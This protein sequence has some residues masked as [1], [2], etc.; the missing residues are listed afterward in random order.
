MG[1]A[2][3]CF[4]DE[5]FLESVDAWVAEIAANSAFS[6]AANKRLLDLT[7]GLPLPAGLAHEV[8][9]GEGVGPDMRERIAAFA[10]RKGG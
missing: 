4:P 10:A 6:H 5:T 1:L 7:D 2:N 9:R 8:Y 3:A